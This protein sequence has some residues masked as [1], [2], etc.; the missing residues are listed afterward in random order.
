MSPFIKKEEYEK[1]K[2][3]VSFDKYVVNNLVDHCQNVKESP[4]IRSNPPKT[5]QELLDEYFDMDICK[6]HP[7]EYRKWINA[8]DPRPCEKI[9]PSSESIE[10]ELG[11]HSILN[12]FIRRQKREIRFV[13][14]V[15]FFA[16]GL[17]IVALA[18]SVI[19]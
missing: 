9:K 2:K 7:C 13:R 19:K 8:A 14:S 6:C 18:A 16:V 1:L 3:A 10:K 4:S 17:S 15:A 5:D 12:E 11:L